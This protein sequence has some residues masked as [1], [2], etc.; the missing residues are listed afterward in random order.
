LPNTKA[1]PSRPRYEERLRSLWAQRETLMREIA[2]RERTGPLPPMFVK[3]RTFLVH[4]W[5]KSDWTARA[6]ILL[7][8]RWLVQLGAVQA[9]LP[10]TKGRR[11]R[12]KALAA[13]RHPRSRI[14]KAAI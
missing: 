11:T 7:T 13:P 1:L 8:A 14:A 5:A 4:F 12:R 10:A 9:I 3:A 2:L 6:E